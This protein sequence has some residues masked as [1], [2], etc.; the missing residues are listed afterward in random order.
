MRNCT[1]PP[2]RCLCTLLPLMWTRTA[3]TL[4]PPHSN[5]CISPITHLL[6]LASAMGW[7]GSCLGRSVFTLT[8]VIGSRVTAGKV[9][10]VGADRRRM[11]SGQQ[12]TLCA[13]EA[14][15]LAEGVH[16]S[17]Q[18]VCVL[19]KLIVVALNCV[20]IPAH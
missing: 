4:P 14:V 20:H 17:L 1:S 7:T 8:H 5:T 6:V 10:G 15:L 12:I 3:C 18:T 13:E 2:L 9:S 11:G 19:G 16:G